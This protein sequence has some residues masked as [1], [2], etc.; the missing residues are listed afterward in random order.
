MEAHADKHAHEIQDSVACD[1]LHTDN[2][3][4]IVNHPD[5]EAERLLGEADGGG[6]DARSSP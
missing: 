4:S 3:A 1:Y 5:R 2:A 6:A